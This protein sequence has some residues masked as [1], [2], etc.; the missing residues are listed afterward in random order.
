MSTFTPVPD[1]SKTEKA[2]ESL[3]KSIKALDEATKRSGYIVIVLT[4]ILVVFSAILI[5]QGL[6]N[7]YL[8]Q[9]KL[10]EPNEE[11]INI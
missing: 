3:N 1:L 10:K 2:L 9:Q 11:E 4:I 5:Y 8:G 6:G 7:S